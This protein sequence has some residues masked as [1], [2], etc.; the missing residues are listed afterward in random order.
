MNL[1]DENEEEE[2]ER[3]IKPR[4]NQEKRTAEKYFQDDGVSAA[5]KSAY[6]RRKQESR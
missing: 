6:K 4:K 2:L 5:R 1:W 3:P